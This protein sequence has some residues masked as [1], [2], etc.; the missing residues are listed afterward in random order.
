MGL[1]RPLSQPSLYIPPRLQPHGKRLRPMDWPSHLRTPVE[2]SPR[3]SRHPQCNSSD[4]SEPG[5][6]VP[7]I[8][9]GRFRRVPRGPHR[10]STS[11]PFHQRHPGSGVV[12]HGHSK[13][14][15]LPNRVRRFSKG[16]PGSDLHVQDSLLA[17]SHIRDCP[18][19]RRSALLRNESQRLRFLRSRRQRCRS[20]ESVRLARRF[21]EYPLENVHHLDVLVFLP[22]SRDVSFDPGNE[23]PY[24]QSSPDRMEDN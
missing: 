3:H 21:R 22:G 9:H 18:I 7:T 16:D 10:S 12:R 4:Q 1:Q 24:G 2:C 11:P 5:L 17:R 19:P 20:A 23:G 8:R 6:L 14:H 15:T 13:F